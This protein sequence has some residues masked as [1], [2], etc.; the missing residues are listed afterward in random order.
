M[1]DG[2]VMT[3]KRT[4]MPIMVSDD[5][6]FAIRSKQACVAL[7]SIPWELI[8]NE[9]AEQWARR[10][11]QQSLEKLARRGGISACEAIRIIAGISYSG[12]TNLCLPEK[13]AHRILRAIVY[14]YQLGGK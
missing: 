13:D 8:D 2:A 5:L 14:A 6:R 10:N 1:N 9:D 4:V 7:T 11:H 3:A 12:S